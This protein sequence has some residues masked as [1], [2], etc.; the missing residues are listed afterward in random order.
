MRVF[1]IVL[2]VA[3]FLTALS[4]ILCITVQGRP[5]KSGSFVGGSR[6]RRKHTTMAGAMMHRLTTAMVCAG[7]ALILLLNILAAH[8]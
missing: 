4:V 6:M 3:L 2:G 1:E 7:G 8:L 5:E